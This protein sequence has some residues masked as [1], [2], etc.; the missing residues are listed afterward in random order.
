MKFNGPTHLSLFIC[1]GPPGRGGLGPLTVLGSSK[2]TTFSYIKDRIYKWINSWR[3]R[4]LSK[5][6][7]EVMIKSILQAHPSYVMSMLILP[8][9]FIE[10][11][12]KYVKCI[13]VGRR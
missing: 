2:E 4:A 7:K 13:L 6:S 5:A 3:G 8:S 11:I 12:E 9:S 10:D 1:P